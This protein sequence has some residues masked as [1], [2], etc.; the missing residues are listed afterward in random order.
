MT[1]VQGNAGLNEGPLVVERGNGPPADWD[2]LLKADPA[3]DYFHTSHWT[4]C[5]GKYYPNM[6]AFWLT[7]RLQ[8]RLVGGLAGVKKSKPVTRWESS[9]EGT[10]GGPLIDIHLAGDLRTR[11]FQEL[12]RAYLDLR[13]TG[14]CTTCL[15]LNH[16]QEIE[17]GERLSG[18]DAGWQHH[19]I[20]AAVIPLDEGLDFVEMKLLKKSKRNERN[21]ALRR[22]ARVV[23]SQDTNL[24]A[25]YYPIYEQASNKWNIA[26]TP[27]PFLQAILSDTNVVGS[28]NK[29]AFFTCVMLDDIVIGGH[30]NLQYGNRVIAWNGVTDPRYART[31]FPATLAIWGDIEESCRRG[32]SVLDLGGSGGVV[33]LEGFKK[34]FGAKNENKGHYVLESSGMKILQQGRSLLKGLRSGSATGRS[35]RLHDDKPEVDADS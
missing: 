34:Y 11:I 17:F 32:A 23:I 19:D 18:S 2:D 30:L 1:N 21:R 3:A 27:L 35:Q 13:G 31:Y 26:P 25:A 12:I 8:G 9:L 15:S 16:Y 7:A 10:S 5:V 28:E 6:E 14:L 20:P 29:R 33:S 22:G 24:L 4:G